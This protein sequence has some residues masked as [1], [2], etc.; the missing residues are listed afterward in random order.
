VASVYLKR[1]TWYLQVRDA[2][3]RRRCVASAAGTKTEAKRLALE[4]ERRFERQ[5]LGLEPAAI[6]DDLRTVDDLLEW[7]IENFL[8]HASSYAST[9]STIRKHLVGSKD[10]GRLDLED[11]S[12]GKVDLFL[13]KKER[14]L[15]PQSVNHLRGFLRRAFNLGRRMEKFPRPNPVADVPK[16]KVPKRLPDYLR[17]EEVPPLLASVLPKWKALFATAIYTGLRKGELFALRKSDVDVGAGLIIVSRSHDR[18]TPKNGRTEAVPI[19]SELLTHYLQQAI[20][21]SPSDLVFPAPDGKMLRKQTQLELILRRAMRRA[22]LVTGYVHKCR[23]KGCGHNEASADANPRR[24]PTCNF[25][26]SAIGQVR[27]IRFHHLRHTTA[28][29]LLMEGADLAAVQR[30]MRH[31]D[32]RMTTEF[33]GHLGAHYL[34]REVERL[35]FG[36]PA[37]AP[38]PAAQAATSPP[39]VPQEPQILLAAGGA[40]ESPLPA[41]TRAHARKATPFTTRLLPTPERGRSPRSHRRTVG[42]D[43][44]G[45]S[46]VGARGFEP[47]A[48]CSQSRR[49]TRLRYAPLKRRSSYTTARGLRTRRRRD[50]DREIQLLGLGALALG[51]ALE[52]G[53]AIVAH[54]AGDDVA[55][56]FGDLFVGQLDAV[57]RLQD[58][59]AGGDVVH[60]GAQGGQVDHGSRSAPHDG[61]HD[62]KI[63]LIGEA[64]RSAIVLSSWRP[65]HGMRRRDARPG[66]F[67]PQAVRPWFVS[68]PST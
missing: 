20:R 41:D 26:L 67:Y 4:M 47:P 12:P 48:S 37:T 59:D 39:H 10:L 44:R 22:G 11:V 38:E 56:A 7:W 23:R 40:P 65:A 58:A 36:P 8:R 21:T 25:K 50:G 31:Q 19:N 32:P 24:C 51:A 46:L 6:A 33:Y 28:S 45:L 15:S 52:G 49:A 9:I 68:S 42:K 29:L 61:V 13:T 2:G 53:D 43:P 14:V 3:G 5:G 55:G 66:F 18:D 27:N 34:K 57:A 63:L 60:Q 30:I 54:Q 35:H 17:P 62:R 64:F 16:R 1:D